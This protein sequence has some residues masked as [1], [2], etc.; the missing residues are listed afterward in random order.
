MPDLG[1]RPD[2]YVSAGLGIGGL[3]AAFGNIAFSNS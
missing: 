3:A 1:S 2:I